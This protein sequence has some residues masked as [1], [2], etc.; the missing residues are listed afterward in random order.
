VLCKVLVLQANS[1]LDYDT[2]VSF[3]LTFGL[4][5]GTADPS[6]VVLYTAG[7]DTV[8]LLLCVDDILVASSCCMNVVYCTSHH[9]SGDWLV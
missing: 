3:V 4:V 6:L 5:V 8:Y 1:E 9:V 2:L 7:K